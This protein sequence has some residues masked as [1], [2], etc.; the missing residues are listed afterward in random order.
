VAEHGYKVAE[1]SLEF[2]DYLWNQ[3]YARCMAK[4]DEA[5]IQRLHDTYLA[6]A[7]E[8]MAAERAQATAVFG[9]E[10]PYVLLLHIGAFDA[11]MFPELVAQMRE[12]GLT[13]TSMPKA[14]EDP[15]YATPATQMIGDGELQEKIARVK[16][17]SPQHKD[18]W[19]QMAILWR[20]GHGQPRSLS[21]VRCGARSSCG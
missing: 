19:R 13:F 20:C 12:E 2:G 3:P 18:A 21:Y 8:H 15:A 4:H 6:A 17:I 16:G 5:A 11:R 14:E 9:H 7:R 10:I 1:V